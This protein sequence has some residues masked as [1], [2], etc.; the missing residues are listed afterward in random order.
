M[1]TPLFLRHKEKPITVLQAHIAAVIGVDA[2]RSNILL[3]NGRDLLID[4]S[5]ADI[6][7][8]LDLRG[9]AAEAGHIDK[10]SSSEAEASPS[11]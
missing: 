3:S 7:S 10:G 6:L 4:R 5:Y 2:T 9:A 1:L 11:E 8:D